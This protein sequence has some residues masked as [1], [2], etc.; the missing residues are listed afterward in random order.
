MF[1][2]SGILTLECTDTH[3]HSLQ[4]VIV[5]GDVGSSS[6]FAYSRAAMNL[7]SFTANA[8]PGAT[9]P[10]FHSFHS[11]NCFT[12]H[13]MV[14]LVVYCATTLICVV[15]LLIL[16]FNFTFSL[17]CSCGGQRLSYVLTS[18]SSLIAGYVFVRYAPRPPILNF[19][20]LLHDQYLS[21]LPP[22]C[23][24]TGLTLWLPAGTGY[25]SA[26]GVWTTVPGYSTNKSR[27]HSIFI[28][29]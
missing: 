4:A 9:T 6:P 10:S 19:C 12:L 22:H 20:C 1:I 25:V 26:L 28:S 3:T 23:S 5:G 17:V 16:H 29:E 13:G 27:I 11:M 24:V 7:L 8:D 21:F 14:N 15:C 18:S 2:T